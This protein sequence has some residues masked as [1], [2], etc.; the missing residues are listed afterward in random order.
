MLSSLNK[1]SSK[2][3]NRGLKVAKDTYKCW[4]QDRTLR[5][6]AGLAYYS[7]FSIIPIAILMVGVAG[8][9]F[10][11][12]EIVD[13]V[14]DSSVNL[15]G[16]EFNDAADSLAENVGEF[17]ADK[18]L[19]SLGLIGIGS[20][21]ITVSFIFLALKDSLDIIW[22]RPV[23][24][25]FKLENSVRK[26]VTAYVVV[27]L[28]STLLFFALLINAVASLAKYLVPGEA[29]LLDSLADLVF[30]VGSFL[31]GV[32]ILALIFKLLIYRD[33]SW[34]TLI[35]GSAITVF[36]VVI[37]TWLL[38]IYL[39]TFASQSLNGAISSIFLVLI[40][41]YYESQIVLAGAQLTKVLAIR[42]D[43]VKVEG[44]N[45]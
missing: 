37:G 33:I 8:W 35:M 45:I 22:H 32:L 41:L 26:Y 36:F 19:G 1:E 21:I 9:F 31:A 7:I 44:V 30:S 25:E 2:Y 40:W 24:T 10:S 6:G 43:G 11:T 12:T 42:N 27:F 29:G 28:S 34:N 14:K 3:V 38:G 5:L 20:L 16:G 15:F 18:G 17:D 23:A 4:V 13:F 39:S